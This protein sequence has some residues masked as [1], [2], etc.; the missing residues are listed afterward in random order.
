MAAATA[1]EFYAD[2]TESKAEV[3]VVLGHAGKAKG[4]L[5]DAKN[6]AC[7]PVSGPKAWHF[8]YL[9]ILNLS[10]AYFFYNVIH[11]IP[12][13]G[14]P[15]TI[16]TEE[17]ALAIDYPDM[18][19]CLPSVFVASYLNDGASSK[20]WSVAAGTSQPSFAA[21]VTACGANSGANFVKMDVTNEGAT[22][23]PA[24]GASGPNP[25]PNPKLNPTLTLT[26]ILPPPPSLRLQPGRPDQVD[27]RCERQVQCRGEFRPQLQFGHHF[28]WGWRNIYRGGSRSAPGRQSY[29]PDARARSAPRRAT[30]H[31]HKPWRDLPCRLPGL[32]R[33][34]RQAAT[35]QREVYGAS[36]DAQ[37]RVDRCTVPLHDCLYRRAWHRPLHLHQRRVR[38]HDSGILPGLPVVLNRQRPCR[39]GT[40]ALPR[41]IS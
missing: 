5:G 19:L 10:L 16:I 1:T 15:V 3:D 34:G 29:G 25:N 28:Y 22:L 11:A 17:V 14:E 37:S 23:D 2:A 13:W 20:A 38:G 4:A 9:L 6:L 40:R 7:A 21:A 33:Q 24:T 31:D 27:H 8:L 30:P 26:L 41:T 32:W 35:A 39:E 18:Y 36:P 12:S